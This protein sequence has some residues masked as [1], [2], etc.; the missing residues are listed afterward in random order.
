VTF[1][2]IV[3]PQK[4]FKF[5]SKCDI[6]IQLNQENDFNQLRL[7]YKQK[8]RLLECLEQCM[9]HKKIAAAAAAAAGTQEN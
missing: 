9:K 2:F 4:S 8:L 7:V 6:W 1:D 3:G 5:S